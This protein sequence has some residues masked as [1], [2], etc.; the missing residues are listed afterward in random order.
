MFLLRYFAGLDVSRM[1]LWSYVIWWLAMVSYYFRSEVRLW[2]TS[3]GIGLVVG[4][5]LMLCT[6]PVSRLRF[7][8]RFW[9]SM[10]LFICPFMVSS[11]SAVVAGNNFALIFSSQWMEN[12]ITLCAIALFL[13]LVRVLN[14]I[15]LRGE[16]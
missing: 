13:M 11:F 15:L 12:V 16:R 6:G 8:D 9:E 4:L 7:R 5:A 10:R 14:L 2:I 3:L 1:I